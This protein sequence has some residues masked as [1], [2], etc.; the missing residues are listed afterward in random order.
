MIRKIGCALMIFIV[1]SGCK[2]TTHFQPGDVDQIKIDLV[3]RSEQPSGT[4]YT[5]KL[6]NHSNYEVVQND[7]YLSYPMISNQG[8]QRQSNKAKVEATGNKLHIKP[9]DELMLFFFIPSRTLRAIR[10]LIPV[11]PNWNSK[12]T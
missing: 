11:I 9:G 1:L 5:F 3:D 6:S 10:T 12:G 4:A 7:L 2:S 8:L